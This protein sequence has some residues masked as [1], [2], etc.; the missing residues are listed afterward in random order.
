MR[1]DTTAIEDWVA[2]GGRSPCAAAGDMRHA[3]SRMALFVMLS[4]LLI[5]VEPGDER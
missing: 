1:F 3:K 5:R 2:N 4:R